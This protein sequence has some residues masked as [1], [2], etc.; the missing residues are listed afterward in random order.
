MF[1]MNDGTIKI[2]AAWLIEQAGWKGKSYGKAGT[3]KRQPLILIN[4][5]GA[6][7]A[8]I[9]KCAMKIQNAVMNMFGIRLEM[10]VNIM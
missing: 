1:A 5:G 10:E 9:L 3:H 4:R 7:G 6:T 2:S 8:E